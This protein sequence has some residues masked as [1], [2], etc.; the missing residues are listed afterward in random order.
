MSLDSCEGREN[1][2]SWGYNLLGHEWKFSHVFYTFISVVESSTARNSGG[3]LL[4]LEEGYFVRVPPRPRTPQDPP[5]R[6]PTFRLVFFL[7]G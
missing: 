6:A 3:F 7:L 5:F 4:R 1:Q 2:P